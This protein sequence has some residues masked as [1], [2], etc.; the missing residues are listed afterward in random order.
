MKKLKQRL[1]SHVQSQQWTCLENYWKCIQNEQQEYQNTLSTQVVNL[2]YIRRSEDVL[3]VF[4]TSHVRLIYVLC[5]GGN[6]I[7]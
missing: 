6:L 7:V 4:L 5:P 2:M 1:F 3:D